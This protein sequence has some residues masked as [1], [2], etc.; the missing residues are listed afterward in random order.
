M[1]GDLIGIE[2][3]KCEASVLTKIHHPNFVV[4]LGY[5]IEGEEKLLVYQFMHQGPLSKHLYHWFISQK[6]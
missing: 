2:T 4:L 5:C 3:F 6:S 1:D